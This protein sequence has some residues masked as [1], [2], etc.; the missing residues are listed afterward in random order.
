MLVDVCLFPLLDSLGVG[1]DLFKYAADGE[2]SSPGQSLLIAVAKIYPDFPR[3][4]DIE[5]IQVI[6]SFTS[7]RSGQSPDLASV[8]R[9]AGA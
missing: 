6:L 1:L 2:W 4:V 3:A 8:S 7:M 9:A 5:V